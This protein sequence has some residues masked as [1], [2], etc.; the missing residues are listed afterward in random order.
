[1]HEPYVSIMNL[2]EP[3]GNGGGAERPLE[4]QHLVLVHGFASTPQVNWVATRWVHQF[5]QAG[6]AVH[7]LTLPYHRSAES[8]DSASTRQVNIAL[9]EQTHLIAATASALTGYLATLPAVAHL[10]GFSFGAR[11]CWELTGQEA[12]SPGGAARPRVASL[13]AGAMPLE[14][15]FPG[16]NRA[17][18]GAGPVPSGFEAILKS[19]PVPRDRL[20]AFTAHAAG[21]L[22]PSPSPTCPV[23]LFAGDRDAVAP[24]AR[25]AGQLL[26]AGNWE[27]YSVTGRDHVNVLTSG[28]LRR[29]A[30]DFIARHRVS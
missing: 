17:L 28:Q 12:Y 2:P 18:T 19:T 25:R 29:A 26:P 15:H 20:A 9:D 4:G 6:A 14:N 5:R 24:T 22:P 8:S 23:L 13:I 16:L 30:V 3:G 1:M 27:W 10:V 21:A 11:V 7:L